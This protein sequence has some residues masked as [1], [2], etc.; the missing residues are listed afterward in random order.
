MIQVRSTRQS[1]PSFKSWKIA[2]PSFKGFGKGSNGRGAVPG[3]RVLV[4]YDADGGTWVHNRIFV[5]GTWDKLAD[6]QGKVRERGTID[7]AHWRRTG[8]GEY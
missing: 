4:V 3:S 2:D 7:P 5:G 1:A 8:R 6:L